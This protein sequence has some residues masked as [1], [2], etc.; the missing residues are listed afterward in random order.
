[1]GNKSL[2]V[3]AAGDVGGEESESLLKNQNKFQIL[4]VL[5]VITGIPDFTI[6]VVFEL[7]IPSEQKK[8]RGI[9]H[10]IV[11]IMKILFAIKKWFSFYKNEV[12]L[13]KNITIL[14]S[15]TIQQK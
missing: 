5:S 14:I 6:C 13:I 12:L 15:I 11:V 7:I 8:A 10:K 2:K 1:M 3:L 9:F 4:H